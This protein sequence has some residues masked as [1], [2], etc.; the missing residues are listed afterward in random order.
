ML[1]PCVHGRPLRTVCIVLLTLLPCPGAAADPFWPLLHEAIEVD[2]LA[3]VLHVDGTPMRIRSFRIERPFATVLHS[4]RRWAGPRRVENRLGDWQLVAHREQGH[5]LMLRLRAEGPERC[6]G[7]L[8]EAELEAA[9][10]GERQLP[11]A[12]VAPAETLIGPNIMMSDGGRRSQ[13]QVLSN[14]HPL[15]LNLQHFRTQFEARGY[16]LQHQLPTSGPQ[17][18]YSL[19]FAAPGK[20]AVVVAY[21]QAHADMGGT[22]VTLS[23]V[24]H[25]ASAR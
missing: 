18:G 1:K 7:T 23:V 14:A 2:E 15:G 8:S 6:S 25:T 20:E 9:T 21:A 11:E 10:A 22:V 4:Y 19:W 17:P 12:L 3:E 13:L 16:R 5:L 24:H